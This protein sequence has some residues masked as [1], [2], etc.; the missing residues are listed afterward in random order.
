VD[1]GAFSAIDAL[2]P[3]VKNGVNLVVTKTVRKE[4]GR[5][6]GREGG[7]EAMKSEA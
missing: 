6:E 4:G 3:R 7:R 1:S 2:T 5:E